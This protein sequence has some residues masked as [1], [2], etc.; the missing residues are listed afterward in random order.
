MIVVPVAGGRGSHIAGIS[1]PQ[2][3]LNS[4]SL[5][6]GETF[7]PRWLI[8]T[9]R[10]LETLVTNHPKRG[11]NISLHDSTWILN[12]FDQSDENIEIASLLGQLLDSID[13][14]KYI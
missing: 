3:S 7:E 14:C 11:F 1:S 9:I 12:V 2:T 4:F 10:A 13:T 8:K 6:D 5:S